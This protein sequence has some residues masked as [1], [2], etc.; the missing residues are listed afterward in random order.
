VGRIV[1]G[2]RVSAGFQIIPH[3]VGQLGSEVRLASL[4]KVL[5]YECSFVHSSHVF[6]IPYALTCASKV[7]FL[8]HLSCHVLRRPH[9]GA[10]ALHCVVCFLRTRLYAAAGLVFRLDL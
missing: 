4:F 7:I 6:A 1:S 5:H 2:V 9:N 10:V 8:S 3:L